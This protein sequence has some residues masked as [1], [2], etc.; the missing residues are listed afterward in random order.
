[1]SNI[2]QFL[3]AANKI[4]FTSGNFTATNVNAALEELFTN[5]IETSQIGA[6]NGVASLDGAG[7]V[8]T[9]QIPDTVLGSVEF[10]GTWDIG[11]DSPDLSAATP[12][13]GDYYVVTNAGASGTSDDINNNASPIT[14]HNG[15]WAIYNGTAWEKVDN[16]ESVSSVFGR[17]GAIVA[18]TGDYNANQ[19]NYNNATSGLTAT[20]VQAAIDELDATVDGLGGGSGITYS[21]ETA[22]VNPA[23]VGTGY[24]FDTG[25]ARTITL[26]AGPTTGDFVVIIDGTGQAATNNITVARNG[27]NIAGLAENL[28]ID[29]DNASI[30]LIYTG[31]IGGGTQ[32][33]IIDD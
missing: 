33:W 31:T 14:F 10:K 11:L 4:R 28:T 16:S 1:M 30:R 6:V 25:A 17:T 21:E 9:S 24:I 2:G 22:D 8:P 12:D 7:K 18:T 23:V 5:K 29:I 15:D 3:R 26:P 20:N 27:N 13:K 19:I 32:G